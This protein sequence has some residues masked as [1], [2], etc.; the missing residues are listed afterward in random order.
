MI[1]AACVGTWGVWAYPMPTDNVSLAIIAL[2]NPPV[3]HLLTYG[4]TTCWLTT[5]FLA[6]FLVLS[7]SRW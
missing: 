7:T 3:F 2:R 4:Y 1:V 5:S 6:A